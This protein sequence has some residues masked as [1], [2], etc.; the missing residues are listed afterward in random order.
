MSDLKPGDRVR[1]VSVSSEFKFQPEL[2]TAVDD[3]MVELSRTGPLREFATRFAGEVEL[4]EVAH[5][6]PPGVPMVAMTPDDIA[7]LE[8]ACAVLTWPNENPDT[9]A[10]ARILK[11]LEAARGEVKS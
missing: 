2:V 4:L 7:A 11:I 9:R 1:M 8:H 3:D 5:Y 10:R 6:A